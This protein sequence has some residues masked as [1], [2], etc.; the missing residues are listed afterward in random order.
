[1]GTSCVSKKAT[2]VIPTSRKT[3]AT[4][5]RATKRPSPADDRIARTL[6]SAGWRS[7]SSA[8]ASPGSRSR[9][10]CSSVA[11]ASG[12]STARAW[13]TE[14][15][16]VVP[17]LDPR[18]IVGAAWCA[19]DGYFD[20]ARA[21][22]EAYAEAVFA[23]GGELKRAEVVT[24][25]ELT[26][27]AIVVAAGHESVSLLATVGVDVPIVAEPRHLFLSRPIAERILEPL[28]V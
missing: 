1:D 27:D 17:E 24:L 26:A 13:A 8:R 22:V 12:S 21:P 19:D 14:A 23:R 28:L 20:N 15:A 11:R 5:R 25:A 10:G 6:A 7:S 16:E 2:N 3:R 4:R 18:G 9:S